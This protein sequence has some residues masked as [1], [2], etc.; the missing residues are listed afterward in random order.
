MPKELV[1]GLASAPELATTSESEQMYLI[2]VAR[3]AETG[4]D[5]PVPISQIASELQVSVPS[6]NEMIRKLDQRGLLSYEPYRGVELSDTGHLIA[7]QVLRTR[8]LW[9]TFLA[10]HLGFSP[11]D[12]DD[13]ACHLE[14]ATTPEAANR[15]ANFLG[16]PAAGPLG[17]PI[18]ASSPSAPRRPTIGLDAVPVGGQVEVVSLSA[19]DQLRD[20]LVAEG[21]AA[22]HKLNVM[23][24]GST[25]LLV[26]S[27]GKA[28]HLSQQLA[29]RIE[30]K[31]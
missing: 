3:A 25:G 7:D 5:G 2:T 22:G 4:R 1:A 6:A 12:A 28:V 14:H 26:E 27:G 10:D 18:P 11:G 30:V 24:S 29:A 13:Q 19:D 16:N 17:R 9:A 15:L 31:P 21:I 23:A 8:R 20:F